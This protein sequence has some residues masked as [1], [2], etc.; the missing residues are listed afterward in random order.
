MNEDKS[1]HIFD[2]IETYLAG[3]LSALQRL[4][5]ES[6]IASCPAC[7]AALNAAREDDAE[8]RELFRGAHPA[9]GFEDKMIQKLRIAPRPKLR[10]LNPMAIR[11]AAAIAAAVMLA[12]T[13]VA[14]SKVLDGGGSNV[15][16]LT[17][18]E[19]NRS[20][21]QGVSEDRWG[22]E[23]LG[24]THASDRLKFFGRNPVVA[25]ATSGRAVEE[26]HS[27]RGFNTNNG[28]V[29]TFDTTK[30]PGLALGDIAQ[31]QKPLLSTESL[32]S[33][34]L[35]TTN[36]AAGGIVDTNGNN[37]VTH[38]FKEGETDNYA[39]RPA[40]QL[41]VLGVRRKD[42]DGDGIAV[43][44]KPDQATVTFGGGVQQQ[45]QDS[46]VVK[47]GL[48]TTTDGAAPQT[49]NLGTPATPG[50]VTNATI[51]PGQA[52][53]PPPAAPPAPGTPSAPPP[54]DANPA[55]PSPA[56][57]RKVIRNGTMEFEVQS[58]D[59]ALIRVTK[60]VVEQ[61]GFIATTDSDKL[62]NG[63]MRG[64][65]T[66]RIPPE[67]L[68]TLSLTLRG[69]G[70]LKSQK[71]TAE[72]VTKHYTDLESQLRASQA[73][74][75][76]LI[77]I[78]KE[79]KGQIKDLVAA[80]KE[81]G[82]WEEKIEQIKGEQRYLDN[83]IGYS[84]L[85]LVLYEKDIK[86]PASVSES[87]QVMMSLETEKVDD[88]YQKAIDAIKE[89]KGRIIQ[90][91]LKQFDA[92]QLGGTIQAAIP[93]DAAEQVI[94]R[95]RQ[96]DGRIAHFS[97][98]RN[99][100]MQAGEV[101]SATTP[102]V[103]REDLVLSMQIYNLA[104]IAP[105]RTTTLQLAAAAVDHAYQQV[106]EQVRSAGGRIVTSSLAKPDPNT[107]VADLDFQVPSDKADLLLETIRGYGEA[108]RQDATENPDT[109]N[110]TEAKRGFH[111]RIVS[112]SAVPARETQTL[113][114][115]AASVPQAF[116]DILTA[117]KGVDG[118]VFQSDLN[119]QNTQDV[120]GAIT[121]EIPRAAT[122]AVNA[123][124]GKSAQVLSR[125][126][127]R[128][129]DVEN[130]VDTK[131]RIALSLISGDHLPPR[132][133]TTLREEV[134]DVERSVDDLINAAVSAGGRRIGNGDITQD[135]AGRVTA[136]VVVD[137]PLASA[138]SVLD[139][140]EKMG[141]RRSKQ[142]AFDSTVPDGPLARARIDATF[143]NSSASLG[144]EET[145]WDAIRHGLA[146]S[147]QGLRWSLQML[148][149]GLCFVAPWV[150][151]LWILIRLI[152][153]SR[154]TTPKPITPPAVPA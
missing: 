113:Q 68:D 147:G 85:A 59:D 89:A 100:K 8:L 83:L 65:V 121:V 75:D 118:R 9:P 133:V 36:L 2:E 91:E 132:Q 46:T 129:A 124:I 67:H 140:L 105:R 141:Y 79:G 22:E 5:F 24:R 145:T 69:I 125:A 104:N 32:S 99:Q 40:E 93:P 50:L 73:M 16:L 49:W 13:G 23:T 114:L 34:S 45:F 78:V 19:T 154:A 139:T 119:E 57:G 97:R 112:L 35:G 150:I 103:N 127:N 21:Q 47:L 4:A 62:P 138:N 149:I 116:A 80:E 18:A 29:D 143:S 72:D 90:S 26:Q 38:Y 128:S 111:V 94:A 30:L 1:P 148:V 52:V 10:L 25:D 82:V 71:I 70:D 64:T 120:T 53:A 28:P 39:F 11:S 63:K 134:S 117:V 74:Y 142:V 41:G 123:T 55:N 137:V 44:G 66:V 15:A 61:G 109:A 48:I 96:L 95:L 110:V 102:R 56:A 20:V 152:R 58:F 81:L 60:L 107:Q 6:H 76:R 153:R 12:G 130:T 17:D 126:V 84:T 146:T 87:E 106:I 98:D 37:K 101:A 115:A 31:K 14:V 151:A 42:S 43:A 3:G 33:T 77:Q 135:R 108:M 27:L 144:G 122:A 51:E 7:A 88:D 54:A 86:T 131:I 136:Q 92:G